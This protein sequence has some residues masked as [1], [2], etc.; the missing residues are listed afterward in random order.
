[1]TSP[2]YLDYNATTPIDPAVRAAMLP[3][4]LNPKDSNSQIALM[5]DA[6]AVI[7]QEIHALAQHRFD[8]V[9]IELSFRGLG[10]APILA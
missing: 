1:M 7:A 4:P 9:E 8:V 6:K 10:I 3:Y 2:I 5:G